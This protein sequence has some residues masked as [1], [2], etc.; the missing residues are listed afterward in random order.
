MYGVLRGKFDRAKREDGAATPHL[1]VRLLDSGGQPWRIAVNVQSDTGSKVVYWVVDPLIHHPI[2]NGLAA[3]KSGFTA[4]RP[5]A[6]QALDCVKAPLFEFAS[7]RALP[8]SGQA[9][10]DD[11]Q[12]L[13][14]LYLDQLQAAG[15]ELFAWGQKFTSNQHRPIDQEFGNRDGLH[16]I[17]DIHLNQGNVGAHAKDNG[18]FQD[19]GLVLSYPDRS[20]GLFLAFQSQIVPTD[21]R[22]NATPTGTAIG[23]LITEPVVAPSAVYLERALLKPAIGPVLVVIG[24]LANEPVELRGWQ[25]QDAAG[26]SQTLTGSSIAAGESVS[27]PCPAFSSG[28]GAATGAGGLVRLLDPTG[29]QVDAA[30]YQAEQARA[31]RYTRF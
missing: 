18:V 1:Q 30:S 5:E 23:T 8:P 7:G 13:L 14:L 12:D 31:D 3:L 9:N 22:G 15:G 26:H 28:A 17:H 11:L 16:G 20:V 6:A 25:L 29:S 21:G 27:V 24:N 4:R 10:D 2:L 19:G